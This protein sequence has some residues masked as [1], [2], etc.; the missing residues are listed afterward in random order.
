MALVSFF[1]SKTSRFLPNFWSTRRLASK[2]GCQIGSSRC[3]SVGTVRSAPDRAQKPVNYEKTFADSLHN[4]D[5]IWGKASDDIVWTK[6]WDKVLDET[7]PIF[8]QW[9]PGG[10]LSFCYNG[11]DRHVDE[12]RGDQ[13]AIVFDSP[14]TDTIERITYRELQ[15]QVAKFAS[16]LV[17]QGV[18][19][20]DRVLI[21]MPMIPQAM[22]AMWAANRIG[23]VHSLVFGGFAAKELST[24]IA[25]AEPKVIVSANVGI[26]P[27][28]VIDYKSLLDE[29]IRL[30]GFQ[31][32]VSI[33][34][35]REG[36]EPAELNRGR[37]ISFDEA[38]DYAGRHDCVSIGAMDPLY[39]LYTSGTTGLPKAVVR[40]AG[41]YAVVLKWSMWNIYGMNPGDTW[42]AAS[43]LGWVVGH[44]YINYAPL[45]NA[46]PT[47]LFEGKPVGTPDASTYFRVIS[48]HNVAAMFLAP[49]ALRA[50]RKEDPEAKLGKEWPLNQFK[51]VFVAGEHCD[52][53][54]MEWTKSIFK[55][56]V[57]DNWWQTETGWPMTST[58]V[59]LGNNLHPVAGVSGRPVPGWDVKVLK[60]DMT[61]CDKSEL[62]NIVVKLPLPPGSFSTIYK[63][64]ERFKHL[65]FENFPGYYDTMDAGMCDSEGYI[66]VMSR[67]DDV[68][69]VAGHRLSTG[70]LEEAILNHRSIADAAVIG[71]PDKLKGSVPLGLCVLQHSEDKTEQQI[72]EEII[73]HIRDVI[74]PVAS[75]KL[76]IFV[77]RLPKT[78][79][80]KIARSTI[81]AMAAGKP[82]KI[83]I[84]IEDASVYPHIISAMRQAGFDA[85]EPDP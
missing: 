31:P 29:A 70:G 45:L 35:Q 40:P 77:D 65:Y 47:V 39:L 23:A 13:V 19:R 1:S 81:S 24:R 46:N 36:Y 54:T 48:Q 7:D 17:E 60:K 27:N 26:E 44:S 20:G 49:T 55:T 16:V 37:D 85:T 50:I 67:V 14:V 38:M 63:N 8:P 79:S 58:C 2:T 30:S 12:G 59:G 25:H 66:S 5:E 3:L 11:I 62:G 71:L 10:E 32:N 41:G 73:Q 61:E 57:L 72:R 83:P 33:I 82:Y 68:I 80:G 28:R 21:Y 74:G 84:T 53:D 42:W 75:F 18:K 76:I 6:K 78:R 22:V 56:P 51:Y 52:H 64:D 9:F 43:D 34:Y 69:N 4:R 15:E